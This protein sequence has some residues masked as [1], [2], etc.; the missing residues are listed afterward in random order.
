MGIDD[1]TVFYR[2]SY[3]LI[4]TVA[5]QRL[6]GHT[7]AEDI[8]AEVFRIAWKHCSDGNEV[9]LPWA[10]G[11]LRNLIG[12]E[13][14][15]LQRASRLIEHA[16]PLL[17]EKL[18]NP[19]SDDGLTVRAAML[20]LSID[21]RELL[22]MAYWEDLTNEEISTL[23]GCKQVTVRVRLMRARKRLKAVL[24]RAQVKEVH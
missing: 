11:V 14:R 8:T 1:F 9:T 21:D 12:N 4:L 17:V 20:T 7:D 18:V 5:E 23:I 22:Y 13:Y 15:R 2:D 3:R 6:Q 19:S 24:D 10:Y 16:A